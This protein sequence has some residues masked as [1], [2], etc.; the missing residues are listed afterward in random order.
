[1]ERRLVFV[2]VGVIAA[3]TACS[4]STAPPDTP[5]AEPHHLRWA[6]SAGPKALS[7]R[8]ESPQA[9]LGGLP[10]MNASFDSQQYTI[11]AVRGET[12][13]LQI[14]FPTD[15]EEPLG[16]PFANGD[17]VLITA[18]VDE[19]LFVVEFEPTG[20]T[21][22]VDTPAQ[23]KVWYTG[24]DEDFDADGDVDSQDAYIDQALLGIWYHELEHDPWS[25]V[26]ATQSISDKWFE[27]ALLHFS[28]YAV[29]W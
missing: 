25:E 5:A 27:T 29:S 10:S 26:G 22:T 2:L 12:R 21:F 18:T 3:A 19:E 20:L 16:T 1:M 8:Q 13:A 23:L 11:W 24:A 7:A 17:S 6:P 28:G 14:D 9:G 4:D 15:D